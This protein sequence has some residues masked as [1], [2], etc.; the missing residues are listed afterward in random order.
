M[1]VLLLGRRHHACL[2]AGT[3]IDPGV[4]GRAIFALEE[5]DRALAVANRGKAGRSVRSRKA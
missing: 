2:Q 3:E 5:V 4:I 1:R